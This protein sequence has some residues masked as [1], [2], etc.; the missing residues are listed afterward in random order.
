M[1]DFIKRPQ[2]EVLSAA[3]GERRRYW[4]DD[5][6]LRIVEES[7]IGHRQVTATARRHGICRSLLTTWRRQYRNGEL[8]SSG[9]VSFAPV[10]VPKDFSASQANPID[11]SPPPDCRV[12]V[13]LPNG[14]RLIVPIGV[15]AE[16]LARILAVV[17]RQ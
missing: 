12:E 15:E 5:D 16:A 2:I 9:S 4:S 10:T 14:R 7:F 8:E 6:K 17:D 11:A 1:S 13:A 3:D